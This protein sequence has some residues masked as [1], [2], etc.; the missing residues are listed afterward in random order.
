M[1]RR[2]AEA[3]AAQ[4]FTLGK[5][6]NECVD[7]LESLGRLSFKDAR[8]IFKAHVFASWPN[9]TDLP[10]STVSIDQLTDVIRRT[11][12]LGKIRTANKLR[13]YLRAAYQVAKSS[14]TKASV[15]VVFKM[16]KVM[17]NPVSDIDANG[18]GNRAD[19]NPLSE[20]EMRTYWQSIKGLPGTRG[21]VLRLHLLT[22]AQ[23]IA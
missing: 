15:P 20:Q 17:Q 9:L 6:L 16:F 11:H 19:R 21:A 12:Q 14:R 2:A 22:G 4:E 1:E 8:S 23:R 10:A 18:D 7:L 13:S 3:V 5:L